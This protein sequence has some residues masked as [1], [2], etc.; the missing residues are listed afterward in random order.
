MSE[1]HEKLRDVITELSALEPPKQPDADLW[2]RF[3]AERQELIDELEY[4]AG[5][6]PA[7]L[8]TV[9]GDGGQE[10]LNASCERI[11]EAMGSLAFESKALQQECTE[12]RNRRHKLA[13]H[14]RFSGGGQRPDA[15][16][17]TVG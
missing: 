13:Q 12:V 8:Q 14:Q 5:R 17:S 16:I 6:F 4:L 7:E 3:A 2:A 11:T 15:S 9:L 1:S 10:S